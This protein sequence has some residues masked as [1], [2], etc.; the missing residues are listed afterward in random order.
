MIQKLV[1]VAIPS[2]LRN[3]FWGANSETG[4]FWGVFIL[5]GA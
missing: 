5:N 3:G 1:L 2:F 4:P